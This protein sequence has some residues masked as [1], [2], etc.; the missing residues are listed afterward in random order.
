MNY[1]TNRDYFTT[2]LFVII[3]LLL[4][5][6][7]LIEHEEV[8]TSTQLF[9]NSFLDGTVLIA[10]DIKGRLNISLLH[11]NRTMKFMNN[12]IQLC[13]DSCS[14]DQIILLKQNNI[15][16]T[17]QRYN[18]YIQYSVKTFDWLGNIISHE[19]LYNGSA[20][21]SSS[22]QYRFIKNNFYEDKCFFIFSNDNY[23]SYIEFKVM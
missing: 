6:C 22:E 14:I 20:I 10:D 3:A 2:I 18:P 9:I 7:Y 15:L 17:Y 21:V 19:I 8:Y 23:L 5:P 11:P 16:I 12:T 13:S 4:S 1:L